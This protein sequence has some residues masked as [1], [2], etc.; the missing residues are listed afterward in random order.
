[1]SES[2]FRV[3]VVDD[4]EFVRINMTAYLED[5][6]FAVLSASSG[7]DALEILEREAVD[8]AAVDMRLPGMD[9]NAF[10]IRA[11]ELRPAIR[12]IVHTGSIDYKIPAPLKAAGVQT[13][14][15][16]LKPLD[17]MDVFRETILSL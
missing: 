2:E 7:E 16:L 17:D 3:L 13:E 12:F 11:N 8:L 9:G 1:M 10:I 6:G 4:D 5:E 14:H 15:V